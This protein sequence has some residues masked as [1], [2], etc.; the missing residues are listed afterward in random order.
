MC[1][2]S[3]GYAVGWDKSKSREKLMENEDAQIYF[4]VA[5]KIYREKNNMHLIK[6]E[7]K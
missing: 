4:N 2:H 7:K 1:K 6:K 3:N 5:E